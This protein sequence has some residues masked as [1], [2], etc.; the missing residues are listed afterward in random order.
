MG[1][2]YWLAVAALLVGAVTG[3]ADDGFAGFTYRAN[4]NSS[5][6][7]LLSPEGQVFQWGEPAHGGFEE[8]ELAGFPFGL[9]QPLPLPA[10]PD[11]AHWVDASAAGYY[12]VLTDD[13]GRTFVWIANPY[14]VGSLRQLPA[15]PDESAWAR[16]KAVASG[17]LAQ[18]QTGELWFALPNTD[19][20]L[21][22]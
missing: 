18:D 19:P 10:A 1:V 4:P 3:R 13:A 8:A 17:V 5:F 11:G 21:P 6:I 9:S 20:A 15:S 22:A 16:V 7:Q 2:A 12:Q 14:E